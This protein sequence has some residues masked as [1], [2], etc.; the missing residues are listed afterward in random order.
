MSFSSTASVVPPLEA[1]R[2]PEGWAPAIFRDVC[3]IN[4]SKPPADALAPAA[5]VSF[6]PM[7]A[8]DAD[9]GAITHVQSRPF[10]EVRKGYTSF[11]DGDVILAKITPCMENGKAAIARGLQNRLGF[12]STEFH[13]LR[14]SGAV[15]PEYVYYFVRQ[16]SFRKVAEEHMTGSVGQRRVPTEFLQDAEIP[17][18]PVPEQK[19][20]VAKV[21]ALLASVNSTR[22]RLA[23][24]PQILKRFRQSVLAA[25]CSGRL[26]E[27]RR[28][29]HSGGES[30]FCLLERIRGIR[31]RAESVRRNKT[32]RA[33]EED[34]GNTDEP[35]PPIPETWALCKIEE[36]ADVRLGGT[37]SRKEPSYWGGEIRWV[38]SGEVANCRIAETAESVTSLGLASSNAKVYPRGSVLIAMI[39]EGKTRGQSAI[40]DIE[41]CTNQNVAGLIFEKGTVDPE[42]VWR[43]ALSKYEENRAG[44]RGGNQPALNGAK[45]RALSLPLPPPAEQREIVRRVEA[46]FK[47]ADSIEKRVGAAAASAEKLTQAILAKAFRGELVPTEAELARREGRGYESASGVA[48]QDPGAPSGAGSDKSAWR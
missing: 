27:D 5:P 37:P 47:L 13:V 39:G 32:L 23:R 10:S 21:G 33:R 48:G 24:V 11:R 6:V 40:L 38:S 25:A 36:I 12:G 2:L 16:E 46:L 45:V 43:W 14:P 35:A 17:L 9:S 19:R 26:T 22:E 29:G 18:P 7:A 28:E 31:T 1:N 30:A 15:L 20:I 34:A 3:G 42:Y 4:P 41:A 44:G 8:V